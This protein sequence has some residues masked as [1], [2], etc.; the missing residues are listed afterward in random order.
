MEPL[1]A[2]FLSHLGCIVLGWLGCWLLWV[3]AV[4]VTAFIKGAKWWEWKKEGATMWQSD[5]FAARSE[6]QRQ[7]K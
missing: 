7:F 1:T 6:A 4:R 5:Q 2:L 3:P